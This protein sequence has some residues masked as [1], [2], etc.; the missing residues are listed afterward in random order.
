M[1]K[2]LLDFG[3]ITPGDGVIAAVSGGKDSL[4]LLR[5][6]QGPL[7]HAPRD[8]RLVAVHLDTGIPGSD[9]APLEQHFRDAG[10]EYE[11]VPAHHVYEKSHAPDA[12]KRPCYICSRLRRRLLLETADRLGCSRIA[13][14]HHR[15]D[16]VET[17]L[18]NMFFMREVSA[19]LPDQPL[20]DGAFHLIRPLFYIREYLVARFARKQQ[21]PVSKVRCPTEDTTRRLYVKNLL[22]QLRKEDP[23]VHNNL[24][25]AMF[26]MYP[27]YMPQPPPGGLKLP[28]DF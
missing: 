8:F 15:D 13:L 19:M 24:F 27:E 4:A 22:E 23:S 21:L 18:M 7:V 11:I 28:K 16:A 17:L 14:A 5:L 9:P 6:L 1:E 25:R 3:M 12:R 20:F 26:R 2:A 10:L